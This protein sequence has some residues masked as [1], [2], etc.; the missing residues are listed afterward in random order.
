MSNPKYPIEGGCMCGQ[1]RMLISA[2][3][4]ITMACHCAGCQKLSASAFSL[5]AMIPSAGFAVVKGEPAIGALH[6]ASKYL[7]CPNCLNW[8]F[9]RPAGMDAFVNVR[10]TMFDVPAWSTPFIET[11]TSEKLSWAST[12]AKQSFDRFPAPDQYGKLIADYSAQAT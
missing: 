10:P 9:T 5:S 4:I 12:A 6:G 7:Y 11:C 1:V 2:P 8:L 3:P